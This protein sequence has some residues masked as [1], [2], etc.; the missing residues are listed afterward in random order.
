MGAA[1]Q[2]P[3][4]VADQATMKDG[5][6]RSRLVH[7][8][9]VA[10]LYGQGAFGLIA[11]AAVVTKPSPVVSE[12]LLQSQVKADAQVAFGSAMAAR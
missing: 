10:L 2:S 8:L 5:T 6:M 11:I 1:G 12:S 3:G 7:C 4:N 9:L